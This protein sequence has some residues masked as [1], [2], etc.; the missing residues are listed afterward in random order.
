MTPITT[1]IIRLAASV[2]L[3]RLITL[4]GHKSH[5][6]IMY[7]TLLLSGLGFGESTTVLVAYA[8]RRT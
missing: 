3:M 8:T 4:N 7:L 1:A 6:I 2:A 5:P